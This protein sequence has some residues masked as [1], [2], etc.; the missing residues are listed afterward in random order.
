MMTLIAGHAYDAVLCLQGYQY[1]LF[2]EIAGGLPRC[3]SKRPYPR[4]R[5]TWLMTSW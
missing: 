2:S 4:K 3:E 1:T 5:E